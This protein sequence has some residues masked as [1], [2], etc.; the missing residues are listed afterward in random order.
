M[1]VARKYVILLNGDIRILAQTGYI[2]LSVIRVL[3]VGGL[4]LPTSQLRVTVRRGIKFVLSKPFTVRTEK[5]LD[6]I[7]L[8]MGTYEK[9]F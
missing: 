5:I 1:V 4:W 8:R 9:V 6:E 7:F 3:S 2:V